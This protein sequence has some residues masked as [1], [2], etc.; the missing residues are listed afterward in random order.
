MKKRIIFYA[1]L[2]KNTP[3]DKIG[4][5]ESGCLKT[6]AIYES[7]GFEVIVI[8][9]PAMSKGKIR[10]LIEMS[11]VP[12][13]LVSLI[14]KHGKS[15]PI[16]IV[17][18]YTKIAFFE[19]ILMDITHFFGNKVIYELRN[20]S[21]VYTYDEGSNR[22]RRTLK[23]LLLKPEIVL[24]QGQ[25][26]VDFIKE[27]WGIERQ[28]Y[29]N[30]IM[31][32]FI[33]PNN[34]DRGNQIKIIYFGRVT[35]SK[36]VDVIIKTLGLLLQ[37]GLDAR[38]DI[39][40]GYSDEYKQKLDA[41]VR[42][43]KV[44]KHVFF[45]GRKNF[46]FIANKLRTSHYFVFPSTEKQEG[47]SNSLTEAMG[48]GVVPIVSKAGFN[49]S[50]CGC[51]DLVVDEIIAGKFADRIIDIEKNGK[52]RDYSIFVYD[53]ILKNFTQSVVG[54]KLIGYIEKLWN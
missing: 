41:I 18:F 23:S 43:L 14:I 15:T 46:D 47:H 49:E 12:L 7:A 8:D 34:I 45:Y 17:G 5:A 2:G 53:R 27:K 9:K 48:C 44:D 36:N 25:E 26:Y 16:H 51:S 32:E 24:C 35:Q 20:G 13:K 4:G 39:I 31:D 50:I 1:P 29:P 21:M 28:Y 19:K 6:K 38:L 22:Y 11:L 10:F 40:G 33:Q 37:Y 54:K 30:Y 42:D 52:W 3:P